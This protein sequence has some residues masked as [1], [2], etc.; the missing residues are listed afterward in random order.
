MREGLMWYDDN[1]Q[2]ELE[3][4]VKQAVQR[5]QQKFGTAPD[6]CYVNDAALDKD[7]L[8]VEDVRV[9]RKSTVPLHNFWV[10]CATA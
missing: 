4:K 8:K 9:L 5:Y 7:E 1:P 10:G 3:E 2:L 6:T